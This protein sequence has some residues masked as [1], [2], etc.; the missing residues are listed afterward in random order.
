MLLLLSLQRRHY[1][2]D[3]HMIWQLVVI[4]IL[5]TTTYV[6][7]YESWFVN[8]D[9]GISAT[10]RSAFLRFFLSF[11]DGSISDEQHRHTFVFTLVAMHMYCVPQYSEPLQLYKL[12][13]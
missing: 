3:I 7:P 12:K 1:F 10:I 2:H 5:Y 4:F 9:W 6:S 13:Y 11:S 8:L